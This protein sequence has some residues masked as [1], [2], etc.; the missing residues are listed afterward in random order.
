MTKLTS[1]DSKYLRVLRDSS[2][3]LTPSS[4]ARIFGVKLPTV[5][6]V[7]KR[8]E[9]L[10]LVQYSRASGV[11]LTPLGEQ[12]SDELIWRHR[13][14]ETFLC[15]ELGLDLDSACEV[16]SKIEVILPSTVFASMCE[17]L[18]HPSSCP[19]GRPIP[20]RGRWCP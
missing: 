7:L 10:N 15:I 1:R 12:V 16:A 18:G 6:S 11:R 9:K 3:P 13:V 4:L 20:H 8:L 17:K 5:L 2:E 14:V 19:H